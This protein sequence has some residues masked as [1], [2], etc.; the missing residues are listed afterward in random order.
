[1]IP[2]TT[3]TDT[4]QDTPTDSPSTGYVQPDGTLS[5]KWL[6]AEPFADLRDNQTLGKITDV[7]GLARQIS[8]L[9]K[10]LGRKRAILP[11]GPEDKDGLDALSRELGWPESPDGYP[12][13]KLEMPEGMEANPEVEKAW[14]QWAHEARLTAQ[15]MEYLTKKTIEW[16][17]NA[18]N[19]AAGEK[20][21][22]MADAAA[23]LKS[24]WQGKFDSNRQLAQT[25]AAAFAADAEMKHFKEAGYLDD[26]H[27][28][29]LMHK[30]GE[31]VSPDRIH[32][33]SDGQTNAASVERRIRD[34]QS[35]KDWLEGSGPRH[36]AIHDEIMQ[37]REQLSHAG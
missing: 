9:E 31:A 34:L 13:V 22:A 15:Q 17:V 35:S 28:L 32:A 21:K 3:V 1:V 26:P 4:T 11:D 20:A 37:L 27:F 8:N 19:L 7:P 14:R 16:N 36:D 6:D 12:E 24:R 10:A 30:V 18:H 29:S 23:G 5:P 33:R 25:A 2:E